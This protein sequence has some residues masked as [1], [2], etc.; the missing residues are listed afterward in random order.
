MWNTYTYATQHLDRREKHDQVL[1]DITVMHP[2][3][4]LLVR[5]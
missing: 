1:C 4:D 5:S 3:L 2:L